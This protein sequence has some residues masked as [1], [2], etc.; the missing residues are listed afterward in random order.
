[1]GGRNMKKWIKEN[2]KGFVKYLIYGA[3][4]YFCVIGLLVFIAYYSGF[5]ISIKKEVNQYYKV[6]VQPN[7]SLYDSIYTEIIKLNIEH[8]EIVY[9][10]VLHETDSCR[11]RLFQTNHNLFGMK[12]S[13][14]RATTS[15]EVV[16]GYAWYPNWRESLLDYALLQM[17]HYKN[18][19]DEE[20][21]ERLRLRYASDKEYI[22]KL[23][24]FI[25]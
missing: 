22:N 18:L 20:Y 3:I 25:K 14:S 6:P 12:C 24:K 11:S 5:N 17:S 15:C 4:S 10:Q 1:M 13:G 23:K 7:Q 2:W 21:Y 9:S 16:N 19:T 8:P